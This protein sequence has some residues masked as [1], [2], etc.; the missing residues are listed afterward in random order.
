MQCIV[1]RTEIKDGELRC[2]CCGFEHGKRHF[3]SEAQYLTWIEQE[4]TPYRKRWM[5]EKAEEE[6]LLSW[7]SEKGASA[8]CFGL[9]FFAHLRRDGSVFFEGRSKELGQRVGEWKKIKAVSAGDAH[10]LG[11]REDGMVCAAGKNNFCQCEVGAWKDIAQIAACADISV[12]LDRKGRI[13]L[14]GDLESG[15]REAESWENIQKVAL[16]EKHILGLD[17]LGRVWAA[18][19]N[20][21]EQCAG[22]TQWKHIKDIAAGEYH[23][24]GLQE[25]GEVLA[26]GSN[27]DGE[28]EVQKWRHMQSIVAASGMSAGIGEDGSLF[29]VGLLNFSGEKWQTSDEKKG[30]AVILGKD[31]TKYAALFWKAKEMLLLTQ[32]GKE[33]RL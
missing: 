24:L 31:E 2:P 9:D 33:Y 26:S 3:L 15:M 16:S 14:C 28:C 18:G 4:L 7:I 10:I 11:L 6:Q 5:E 19:S 1:C 23:S 21:S 8:A 17:A 12:A 27:V 13:K 29:A 32:E 22:V 20:Q 30:M 25:N